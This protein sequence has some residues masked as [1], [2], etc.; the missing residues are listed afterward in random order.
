ME[1]KKGKKKFTSADLIKNRQL[2]R[3]YEFTN[4][5]VLKGAEQFVELAGYELLEPDYMGFVRPALHAKRRG[6][7]FSH[8]IVGVTRQ[9]VDEAR[10]GLTDLLSIQAV[11]ESVFDY[12]LLTPP[13]NEY[14][15]LEF[16][17]EDNGR[18]LRQIN[19]SRLMM[20]MCNPD[21]ETVW[22]LAGE[23][24]DKTFEDYFIMSRGGGISNI[25]SFIRSPQIL[26]ELAEE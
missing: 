16:F 11:T 6:E 15:F 14:Q 12:A 21:K 24:R 17:R 19:E 5:Q 18:W 10:D 26:Q 22:C 20:W 8:E 2:F 23:P 3:H 7:D 9:N 13:L 4:E 1:E 25:S